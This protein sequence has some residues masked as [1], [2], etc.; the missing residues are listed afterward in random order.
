MRIELFTRPQLTK[1]WKMFI[2]IFFGRCRRTYIPD[3][4]AHLRKSNINWFVSSPLF[5]YLAIWGYAQTVFVNFR[6]IRH[7][8]CILV[9]ENT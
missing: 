9:I 8:L 5:L 1:A 4:L 2:L 6:F 7:Y 3:A